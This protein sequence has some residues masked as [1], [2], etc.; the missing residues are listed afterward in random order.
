[1][2]I[3][4]KGGACELFDT[5]GR[6]IDSQT[7]RYYGVWMVDENWKHAC[8]DLTGISPLVRL[9]TETFIVG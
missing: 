9:R 5:T 2:N 1:M 6:T 4:R 3:G 8:V 7:D